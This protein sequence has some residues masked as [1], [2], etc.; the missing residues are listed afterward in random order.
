MV[1]PDAKHIHKHKHKQSNI[2]HHQEDTTST[3]YRRESEV[4]LTLV[5]EGLAGGV[6][7]TSGPGGETNPFSLGQLWQ[8]SL[9]A[10]MTESTAW[11]LAVRVRRGNCFWMVWGKSMALC[12]GREL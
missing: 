3:P 4:A 8:G 10:N 12:S 11:Y 1:P 2:Y 7:V 5:M 9:Q 6:A